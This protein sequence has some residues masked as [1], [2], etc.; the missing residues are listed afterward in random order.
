MEDATE[1]FRSRL[2]A[3]C[4]PGPEEAVANPG[5]AN[6]TT[7]ELIM[8]LLSATASLALGTR[9]KS[10][11]DEPLASLTP[12]LRG[13]GSLLF[14]WLRPWLTLALIACAMGLHSAL[15]LA[16]AAVLAY[17]MLAH[18]WQLRRSLWHPGRVP[19][20]LHFADTPLNRRRASF[21]R[22]SLSVRLE[23]EIT[24]W[25][26][27]GDWQTLWPFL[28]FGAA[29]VQY[30]RFW[31]EAHEPDS[32]AQSELLA[33]DVALPPRG[34]D[35]SRPVALICHGLNGG[36]GEAYVTDCVAHL[37][38]QG[39]TCAVMVS[40]G[41][42]GTP[43]RSG[44]L[45]HGAR[46]SDLA[47]AA[48]LLSRAVD[49]APLVG[50]GF[51]MGA[52]VLA[53]FCGTARGANP[54]SCAVGLSGCYDCVAN[55]HFAYG[56]EYW[57]PWLTQ[58]LKTNYLLRKPH[59][60]FLAASGL[61]VRHVLS[62]SVGNITE[63]DSHTV[64][65]YN[66]YADVDEYYGAMSLAHGDKLRHV[67]VPLIALHATD[68]PIIECGT[69]ADAL[70]R[71]TTAGGAEYN[72]NLWFRITRRGGHVGWNLGLV[73]QRKRWLFMHQAVVD[74]AAAVLLVAEGDS[75]ASGSPPTAPRT[76]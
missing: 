73:P 65:P 67:S 21:L 66:G 76:K 17:G 44:R 46:T 56:R 58:Q 42:G 4:V 35:P 39:W 72:P 27:T 1:A 64:V 41:L 19:P 75:D 12:V 61:D 45:F 54:L 52:I 18:D 7:G 15:P 22:S 47:T 70:R 69:F 62:A 30:E 55:R 57:Q 3:L 5:A 10:K 2:G 20:G 71:T 31:F 11:S 53:N 37:G 60:D 32:E 48:Q 28:T 24:R 43:I 74:F 36:S 50:V 25:L 33:L 40:R 8:R 14:L 63:F 6:P 13:T 16:P 49:G 34:F 38:K 23:R 26:W 29:R 9:R 51:S 68:D 59:A